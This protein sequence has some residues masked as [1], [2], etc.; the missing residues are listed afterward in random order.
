[1]A[2]TKLKLIGSYVEPDVHEKLVDWAEEEN[3][4]LSNLAATLLAKA[5]EE[6]EQSRGNNE[7]HKNI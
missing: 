2:K 1:M 6:R 7:K 3:R 4:S 5:V